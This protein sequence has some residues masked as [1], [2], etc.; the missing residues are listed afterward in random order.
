MKYKLYKSYSGDWF[1][2]P[3]NNAERDIKDY[4]K[5]LRNG[6]EKTMIKLETGLTGWKY[7]EPNAI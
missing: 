4:V 7:Y 1:K 3:Y 2:V 5:A 6:D